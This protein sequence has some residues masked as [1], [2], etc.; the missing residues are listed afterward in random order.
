MSVCVRLKTCAKAATKEF[1]V[2]PL[3]VTCETKPKTI[4]MKREKK[5]VR[6][7]YIEVSSQSKRSIYPIS[8][9][10]T[11]AITLT[12]TSENKTASNT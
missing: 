5:M 7:M 9:E 3:H 8:F 10:R 4:I 11:A 1:Q 2:R 12:H 6:S